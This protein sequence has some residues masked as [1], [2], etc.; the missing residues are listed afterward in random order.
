M[1]NFYCQCRAGWGGRLCDRGE[2]LLLRDQGRGAP[3]GV[4][5]APPQGMQG[6]SR[7]LA[8][9]VEGETG[10][11]PPLPGPLQALP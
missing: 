8:A 6:L 3:G 1:G 9:Q 5:A 4:A 11:R 7:D 2:A 10:R